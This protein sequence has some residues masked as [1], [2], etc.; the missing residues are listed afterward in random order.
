MVDDKLLKD[1]YPE[2]YL[3]SY[4]PNI[5]VA[6]ALQKWW[7]G[8]KFRRTLYGDSLELSKKHKLRCEEIEM[9]SRRD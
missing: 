8:F 9:R 1:G 2:L 7:G 6:E 3:L 5:T 4:D